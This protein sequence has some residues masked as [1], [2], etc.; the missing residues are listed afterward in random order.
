[1]DRD[2]QLANRIINRFMKKALRDNKIEIDN[3]EELRSV[4]R[5]YIENIQTNE[6]LYTL[7]NFDRIFNE[8]YETMKEPTEIEKLQEESNQFNKMIK[9]VK[10]NMLRDEEK[11]SQMKQT[12]QEKID[13]YN[14]IIDESKKNI[15]PDKK[16][17][18]F[19]EIKNGK[20]CEE[21]EIEWDR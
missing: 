2:E 7:T 12:L 13:E 6:I 20:V 10:R 3:I 19:S 5:G 15:K 8:I 9:I 17:L 16:T 1:M 21:K 11:N 4:T 18:K 14:K